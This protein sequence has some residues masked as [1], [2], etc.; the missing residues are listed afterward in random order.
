MSKW[1]TK[2]YKASDLI[3]QIKSKNIKIPHYQRGQVWKDSQKETL[4]DSI[5]KGYP[6]GTILLYEKSYPR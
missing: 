1:E 4:I 3:E 5:K 2:I 6:F